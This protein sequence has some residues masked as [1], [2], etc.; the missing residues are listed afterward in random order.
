MGKLNKPLVAEFFSKI[1]WR[2]P[3]NET[4][5]DDKRSGEREKNNPNVLGYWFSIARLKSQFKVSEFT[6]W[7]VAVQAET[8]L[9]YTKSFILCNFFWT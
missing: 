5:N 6:D 4:P 9:I 1:S 2:N 8:K 7:P 3:A